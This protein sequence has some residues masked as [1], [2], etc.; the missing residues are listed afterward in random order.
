MQE[1]SLKETIYSESA[2]PCHR[3]KLVLFIDLLMTTAYDQIA[4][5]VC[6]SAWA[7]TLI[8]KLGKAHKTNSEDDAHGILAIARLDPSHP[9]QFCSRYFLMHRF[10]FGFASSLYFL[11]YLDL[12]AGVLRPA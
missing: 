4:S 6:G 5:R 10:K 11:G 8:G 3:G 2:A 1:A 12:S 7:E 9:E